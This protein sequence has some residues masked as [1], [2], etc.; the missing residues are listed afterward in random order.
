MN[1]LDPEVA[2][3]P[4]GPGGLRRHWQGRPQLG[5]LPRHRSRT[6]AAG[7]EETLLVQSGKPVA[8]FPTHEMAP[9]VI[10]ANS[11]LVGKWAN[12]EH[13]QRTRPQGP[14]DVR[15]DDRRQLDLHRHAGNFAGHLSD[16]RRAGRSPLRRQ[17]E[18][19]AGRHRR[20]GRHGRR[21]AACPSR[22]TTAWSWPST[23]TAP[24]RAPRG[25]PL[26]RH[27]HRRPGRSSALCEAARRE[28]RALSVGL[29]G[30]CADVLPEIVRRGVVVDVVATELRVSSDPEEYV[31]RST[32]TMVVH[33][34]AMLALCNSSG[35]VRLRLRQ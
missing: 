30:N 7:H 5:V 24:H 34:N 16:L 2:E 17:P 25:D 4:A 11:N 27:A 9:R 33:V 31:R 1:N 35:A 22:S 14:D 15:P 3:R 32:E 29:V 18:G 21:A 12:W 28:G 8:V 26:L 13:F 23:W 10:I 6:R 19:K 20:R